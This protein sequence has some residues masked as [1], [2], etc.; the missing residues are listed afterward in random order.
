MNLG[1]SIASARR[2][3]GLSQEAVAEQL[4]ISRQ[5]V[6]KWET[7]E[8]LP[9]IYQS[10]RLA[11]LY[12]LTLDQ[13]VSFDADVAAIEA[14]VVN[15]PEAVAQKV[16]WTSVWAKKY[17][18]LASYQEVVDVKRYAASLT[19]Q[20]EELQQRY[21]FSR[22]DAFLVLKDILARQLTKK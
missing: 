3:R 2:K 4:G 11:Q 6:S 13:L 15:T 21:G 19:A 14:A 17:P 20:L 8:T 16:D 7:G 18:V 12:G 5:T 1:T 10:K 22:Q 9:D